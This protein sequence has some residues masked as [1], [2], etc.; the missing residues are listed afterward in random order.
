MLENPR[1]DARQANF[2]HMQITLTI[3]FSMYNFSNFLL[4]H[5]K[6]AFHEPR[7]STSVFE[8]K[9][10][11]DDSWSRCESGSVRAINQSSCCSHWSAV[12]WHAVNP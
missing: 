1:S 3:V 12:N 6:N 7:T 4:Y 8:H 5:N 2:M 11:C 10:Y 9:D